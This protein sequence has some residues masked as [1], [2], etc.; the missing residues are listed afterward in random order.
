MKRLTA[1]LVPI[2]LIFFI[3]YYITRPQGDVLVSQSMVSLKQAVM[4]AAVYCYAIEGS[5]PSDISYLE[6]KYGL[7]INH[8]KFI[9]DYEVFASNVMPDVIV[10]PK[11]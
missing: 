2:L 8:N 4:R 5:Y 1:V 6:D 10:I 7:I 9:V 3:V 11:N